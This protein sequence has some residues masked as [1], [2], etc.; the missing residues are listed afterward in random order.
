MEIF[1][2]LLTNWKFI[3]ANVL[4]YS[5]IN[6]VNAE[7]NPIFHLLALLGAHHIF[8]VSGLRVNQELVFS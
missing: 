6:P 1:N 7:L 5:S 8:R 3:T 4:R 2:V